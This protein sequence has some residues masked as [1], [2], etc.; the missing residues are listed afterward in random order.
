VYLSL[1]MDASDRGCEFSLTAWE[2]T[3]SGAL[4]GRTLWRRRGDLIWDLPAEDYRQLLSRALGAL[5]DRL[6]ER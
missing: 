3:S 2:Q 6:G 1:H 4:T 5:Q